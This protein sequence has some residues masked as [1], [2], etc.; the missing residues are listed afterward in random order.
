MSE[1]DRLRAENTRLRQLNNLYR[2]AIT[3]AGHEWRNQLSLLNLS[4]SRLQYDTL[5][6][7]QQTLLMHLQHSAAAM[8]RIA[9]QYMSLAHVEH[10]VFQLHPVLTNPAENILNPVFASFA[11]LLAD[12][13]QTYAIN[14]SR[15]GLLVWADSELLL[16][17]CQ[18][19]VGAAVRYSATQSEIMVDVLE[20]VNVDEFSFVCSNTILTNSELQQLSD[21]FNCVK[22]QPTLLPTE[23]GLYL[24]CLIINAHNGRIDFE[25]SPSGKLQF[26]FTLPKRSLRN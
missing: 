17:A 8:L 9:H 21:P 15:P 6:D 2:N 12:R 14:V 18:N 16:T 13:H 26:T 1:I 23:I 24:A 22:N 7:Q 3:F 20:R 5:N 4:V 11:H 19:I 25:A 10:G